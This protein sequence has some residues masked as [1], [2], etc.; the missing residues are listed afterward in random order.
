M[1]K[2]AKDSGTYLAIVFFSMFILVTSFLVWMFF[3]GAYVRQ[4]MPIFPKV[5]EIAA[6][7]EYVYTLDNNNVICKQNNDGTLIWVRGYK[8]GGTNYI[9]CDEDGNLCRYETRP[10]EIYV[11]G[12][13]GSVSESY[14]STEDELSARGIE[15]GAK[16]VQISQDVSYEFK[17]KFFGDSVI[18]VKEDTAESEIVVES[19]SS[20][21]VGFLVKG[22]VFVFYA[23]LTINTIRCFIMYYLIDAKENDYDVIDDE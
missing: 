11:Y 22:I 20:H 5:V 14:H 10:N 6:N 12:E 15:L 18:L 23:F 3:K 2:K 19:L 4:N 1:S 7:G 13:D 16:S 17:D 21:L 8:S 9:F